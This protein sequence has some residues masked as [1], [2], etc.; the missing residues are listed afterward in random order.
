MSLSV[1]GNQFKEM[2]QAFVDRLVAPPFLA[3]GSAQEGVAHDYDF[4]FVPGLLA[5]VFVSFDAGMRLSASWLPTSIPLFC[6]PPRG[7]NSQTGHSC[8]RRL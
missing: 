4:S 3:S 8:W 6:Q 1:P 7:P 5:F 2:H